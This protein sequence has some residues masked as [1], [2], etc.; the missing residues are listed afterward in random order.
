[1]GTGFSSP[2]LLGNS[3]PSAAARPRCGEWRDAEEDVRGV[4]DLESEELGGNP[5]LPFG[6]GFNLVLDT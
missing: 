4:F 3:H 5:S 6:G 2:P 1:M